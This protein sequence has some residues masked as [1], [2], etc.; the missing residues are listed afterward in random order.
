MPAAQLVSSAIERVLNHLLKLDS[1]SA[2]GLK[3]LAGKQLSVAVHELPWPLIFNFS[4]RV[5][6][7]VGM[8][9]EE[10]K[11][12]CH[13]ALSIATLQKLKDTSQI[14]RLIQNNDLVLEG[15]LKVAQQFSQLISELEI[16]WEEQ[17]SQYT[18]DLVA[19]KAFAF[20]KKLVQNTQAQANRLV[21]TLAD[22]AIEEK[23]IAAPPILVVDFCDQV[24]ELRSATDRLEA[25]LN[26]LERQ[27]TTKPN[28]QSS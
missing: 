15:D 20:G 23:R 12:D 5:D 26:R 11:G 19:H 22:A 7:L 25:K 17:L 16:D 3:K 13:L 28:K 10:V 9:D 24:N 14:T 1:D 21:A 27:S 18:G 2:S 4:D 8:P 6:V